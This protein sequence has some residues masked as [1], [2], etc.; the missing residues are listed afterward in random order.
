MADSS[1]A[2][3]HSPPLSIKY[4]AAYKNNL[5]PPAEALIARQWLLDAEAELVRI[6][7]E[8]RRLEARRNALLAPVKAYRV[9]LAPHKILPDDALRDIF[10]WVALTP[11][12]KADLDKMVYRLMGNTS[13][14][15][16]DTRLIIGRVCSHWRLV[17]LG[18]PELWSN[19][20]IQGRFSLLKVVDLW[21]ARSGLYPISLDIRS[22]YDSGVPELLMRYSHRIRSLSLDCLE[23]LG[24][25]YGSMDLLEKL[26]VQGAVG[27][28]ASI[29]TASVSVL[30]GA[31]RLRSITLRRIF[32]PAHVNLTP[33]GIPWQQL[34]EFRLEYINI[35]VLQSYR[36]LE[37]CAV[38]TCARLD[39][40]VS[41]DDPIQTIGQKIALP[42][43]RKLQLNGSSLCNYAKFLGSFILPS[44]LELTLSKSDSTDPDDASGMYYVP[45]T[46]PALRQLTIY[47]EDYEEHGESTSLMPWLA[48]CPSAVGVWL[49]DYVMPNSLLIQIS[50][51]SLLPNL[52]ILIMVSA[53][54]P[55]LLA[56]LQARQRSPHHSTI[57]EVGIMQLPWLL[58]HE[59]VAL[60]E[61][62]ELGVFVGG[63]RK[64][65]DLPARGEIE[66]SARH[67]GENGVGIFEGKQ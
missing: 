30:R 24:E 37:E 2:E 46:F 29:L 8:I 64:Y 50:E 52:E 32:Q 26:E 55:P 7:K 63:Y 42:E 6:D 18:M 41:S 33:L 12:P 51:G 11:S 34:T 45:S 58:P 1:R 36:I 14:F 56:T 5:V 59:R 22:A 66:K 53:Q 20:G 19:V 21:L 54:T 47:T 67:A 39:L 49:P 28:E 16:L 40:N 25:L 27:R 13:R 23:P 35:G 43:L 9:S 61:L 44:L 60:A 48:A 57:I 3:H 4:L 10:L 38:L 31:P 15:Y 65:G 17:A 62:M